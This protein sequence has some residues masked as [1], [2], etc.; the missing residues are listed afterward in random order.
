MLVGWSTM[1]WRFRTDFNREMNDFGF[2]RL[3]ELLGKGRG[4]VWGL[5][6]SSSSNPTTSF[7][8]SCERKCKWSG[9]S[10]GFRFWTE[11]RPLP[12]ERK[13][14]ASTKTWNGT[15]KLVHLSGQ[16]LQREIIVTKRYLSW[17]KGGKWGKNKQIKRRKETNKES[18]EGINYS[19]TSRN[20]IVT[21][22]DEMDY[23]YPIL[24]MCVLLLHKNQS[25][26]ARVIKTKFSSS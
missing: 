26:K 23:T 10:I 25:E 6:P 21:V 19:T 24:E 20:K 5:S 3:Q 2:T 15:T 8:K 17:W 13:L 4:G 1:G 7:V 16:V 11:L 12:Y 18:E 9:F 14:S 22:Y